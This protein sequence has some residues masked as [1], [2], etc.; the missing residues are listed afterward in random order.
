M[1]K[2]LLVTTHVKLEQRL[3]RL[4]EESARTVIVAHASEAAMAIVRRQKPELA[5][6]DICLSTGSGFDL[7][8]SILME[9]SETRIIMLSD[10]DTSKARNLA[11]RCGARDLLIKPFSDAEFNFTVNKYL[12]DLNANVN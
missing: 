4:F 2:I 9:N 3:R 12:E 6:V 7:S 10:F 11:L 8:Q 1:L 5:I